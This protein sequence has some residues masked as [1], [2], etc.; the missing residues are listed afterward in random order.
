MW[1]VRKEPS[2]KEKVASWLEKRGRSVASCRHLSCLGHKLEDFQ[3]QSKANLRKSIKVVQVTKKNEIIPAAPAPVEAA[4][5]SVLNTTFEKEEED[6]ENIQPPPS[7]NKDEKDS[8]GDKKKNM[9]KDDTEEGEEEDAAISND[10]FHTPELTDEVSDVFI[11]PSDDHVEKL[12]KSI[13]E[14]AQ[15]ASFSEEKIEGWLKKSS[16]TFPAVKTHPLY[17]NIKALIAERQG[18]TY[19]ALDIYNEAVE[20]KAEPLEK[21]NEY[22]NEFLQR[23]GS[24]IPRGQRTP[25]L[26]SLGVPK[27]RGSKFNTPRRQVLDSS[28]AFDSSVIMYEVK[29]KKIFQ[30]MQDDLKVSTATPSRRLTR[31]AT[32]PMKV[33]T[34]S[35]LVSVA[36]DET[37]QLVATPV[38]R[39]MRPTSMRP[40]SKVHESDRFLYVNDLN[41]LSPTTKA[42]VE[43]RTNSA[44]HSE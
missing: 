2:E 25:L 33:T 35:H 3:P 29:L 16:D 20:N 28:K 44:L 27:P 17:W 11:S 10:K 5:S 18:N 13:L 8:A 30:A 26:Q 43:L 42:K 6:K 21:M 39:S 1:N 40:L 38:R 37:C 23:V 31:G 4:N 15:K 24:D 22:F 41:Q 19:G 32:T 14:L 34:N 9:E 7:F 12:L 36:S